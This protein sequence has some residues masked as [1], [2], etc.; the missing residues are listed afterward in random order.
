MKIFILCLLLLSNA[1]ATR[2]GD[3][4]Y[5]NK[6]GDLIYTP[7]I[8]ISGS[9]Q[10]IVKKSAT[11]NVTDS[12]D[13]EMTISN[14]IN[15]GLS[16]NMNLGLI[17]NYKFKSESETKSSRNDSGVQTSYTNP[18]T[19][20]EGIEDPRVFFNYRVFGG[21]TI[22]DINTQLL[23]STGDAENGTT[24][25]SGNTGDTEGN[26]L[27]GGHMAF[28]NLVYGSDKGSFQWNTDL[29]VR[30]SFKRDIVNKNENGAAS[31][32]I[33]SD[34]VLGFALHFNGQYELS[35]TFDL[36]F[37]AGLDYSGERELSYTDAS[38]R[39]PVVLTF[40]SH[41]DYDLMLGTQYRASK[42]MTFGLELNYYIQSD[43]DR[44]LTY[45]NSKIEYEIKDRSQ[46]DFLLA[47]N[48]LF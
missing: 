19:T 20:N 23:F 42:S 31:N 30:Y 25:V 1:Y 6:S 48:F 5:F 39:V 29:Q 44:P 24:I 21:D 12:E 28:L 7:L 10:S 27:V 43:Y 34:P 47:A 22:F 14:E 36:L 35:N 3:L 2:F 13:D 17:I 11:Q 40:D 16:D 8:N 9:E 32:Q 46:M 45:N 41:I 38:A 18:V 33:E 26:A 15:Y 37:R 4:N